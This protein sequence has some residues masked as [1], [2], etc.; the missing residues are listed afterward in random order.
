MSNNIK[1]TLNNFEQM[2]KS[3]LEKQYDGQLQRMEKV[4]HEILS[5]SEWKQLNLKNIHYETFV[6]VWNY[7]KKISQPQ[8]NEIISEL[9]KEKFDLATQIYQVIWNM[10]HEAN[11]KKESQEVAHQD[12]D[13]WVGNFSTRAQKTLGEYSSV[14]DLVTDSYFTMKWSKKSRTEISQFIYDELWLRYR[15]SEEQYRK[16]ME[17]LSPEVT[18]KIG[19][20]I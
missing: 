6:I 14:K 10:R 18:T 19:K 4:L 20:T 16:A 8:V 15:M 12:I 13:R 17:L 9:H 7:S 2:R 1:E 11:L 5:Y 3:F